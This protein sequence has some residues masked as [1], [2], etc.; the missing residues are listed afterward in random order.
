L[1]AFASVHFRSLLFDS[2][3][4]MLLRYV[5]ADDNTSNVFYPP[6]TL[7]LLKHL[8]AAS[9][10]MGLILAVVG[11]ASTWALA[12]ELI[13]ET[14]REHSGNI[15]GTFREYS[16]NIQCELSGRP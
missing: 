11:C 14:F 15:Q 4:T 13:Q 8:M 2:V 5:S 9:V 10:V 16:R 12:G 1:L 7:V 6:R 3:Q